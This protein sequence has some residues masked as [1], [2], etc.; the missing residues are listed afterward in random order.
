MWHGG[1]VVIDISDNSNPQLVSSYST[2]CAPWGKAIA[3]LLIDGDYLYVGWDYYYGLGIFDISDPANPVK[4]STYGGISYARFVEKKD[5]Y[6]FV[7]T[8]YGGYIRIFDVS[9][10]SA[11]T[12]VSSIPTPG[13]GIYADISGNYYYL[14]DTRHTYGL[15]IYDI[16]DPTSPTLVSQFDTTSLGL[17]WIFGIKVYGD[18]AI[19][20]FRKTDHIVSFDISNPAEPTV[21]SILK[22]TNLL[23][24]FEFVNNRLYLSGTDGMYIWG[25]PYIEATI[26]IKPETINL[27]S[28]GKWVT[29][30]IELPDGYNVEDINISTVKITE[31]GREEIDPPIYAETHPTSIGDY[32]SDGIQDLMVKFDRQEL[33]GKLPIGNEVEIL[34]MGELESGEEFRGSDKVRVIEGSEQEGKICQAKSKGDVITIEYRLDKDENVNISAYATSGREIAKIFSGYKN[35]GEHKIE[36]NSSQLR[37]G[38]Y[39]IRI[40]GE[41]FQNILKV[42]VVK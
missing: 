27:K 32:G 9:N 2:D 5:N 10:P 42:A 35:K 29:C 13:Y 33:Q 4:V 34:V 17:G 36:W 8:Y 30:Y 24:L 25:I 11:P 20:T 40:K 18:E 37:T 31:V 1:F 39:L 41:S 19:A 22:V 28:H 15:K 21:K 23:D 26:D 6:V 12:L 7:S 14:A 16:T 3:G 38:L